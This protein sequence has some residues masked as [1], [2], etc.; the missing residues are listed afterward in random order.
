MLVNSAIRNMIRESKVHQIDNV[1]F[2][3]AADGMVS[4]DG[5]LLRLYRQKIISRQAALTY[6][7][8]LELMSKKLRA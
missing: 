8:N 4:M 3:G 5:S 1:I 2:A 6:C 7:T